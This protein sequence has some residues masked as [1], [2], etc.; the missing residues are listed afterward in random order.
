M[1]GMVYSI[2]V[3]G[4]LVIVPPAELP[5]Q[6]GAEPLRGRAI[7]MSMDR[8]M[9]PGLE[10]VAMTYHYSVLRP[11]TI[12]V[13][14]GVSVFPQALPAGV[15]A[16]APDIGPAYNLTIPGGSLLIRAGGSAIAAAGMYGVTLV[17][18]AHL[19]GTLLV[20]TGNL[21][22][23][24]L[25]VTHRRYWVDGGEIDGAW[26]IGLGFAILPRRR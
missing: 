13:E 2:L 14:L 7:G 15:L 24:R 6:S 12:G 17:P 9:V 23:A 5:A 1:R 3:A 4:A 10:M 11:G 16:T 25:D 8:F 21:S 20:K 19:G 18:G 26:S 22:A